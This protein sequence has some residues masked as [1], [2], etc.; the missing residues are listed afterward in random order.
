MN[1]K[2]MARLDVG[3]TDAEVLQEMAVVLN[4]VEDI[5]KETKV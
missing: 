4:M 3:T 1:E 5:P 2:N